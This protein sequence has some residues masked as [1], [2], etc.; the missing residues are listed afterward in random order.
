MKLDDIDQQLLAA[1]RENAR[2]SVAQ[3]ARQ[4]GRSRT[5]VLAR[6]ARMERDGVIAGYTLRTGQAFELSQVQA[7]VM[8][9]VGPKKSAS[10]EAGVRR[11]AQVRSLLSVSGEYDMIAIVS[12]ESIERL[13]HLVD[14]LGLLDGVE[15]TTTAVVLSSR[16]SR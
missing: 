7:H 10:V 15:R 8:L 2:A 6:L 13:D 16:I 14:E 3:L 5:A 9:K 4:L 11:I 1:L 12:A